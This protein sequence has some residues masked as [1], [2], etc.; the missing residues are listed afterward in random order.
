MNLKQQIRRLIVNECA[1]YDS[2]TKGIK[3]IKNIPQSI[4][5][6]DY[7]DRE[8]DKDCR[9]LI[10]K[11]KRCEYFERAVLPI[12][13]QLESLYKAEHI[14]EEVGYKLTKGDKENILE[15]ESSVKGKVKIHCKKCGKIFLAD[16]Y[17]QKY[18]KFCKSAIRRES[19]RKAKQKERKIDVS[20][21]RSETVDL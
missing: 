6:K 12:N 14:A 2:S 9:C 4:T 16:H 19:N 5:I 21:V 10:F 18:C 3:Y 1:C 11:D 17:N 20:K 8:Q 13:P 7:C 15:K